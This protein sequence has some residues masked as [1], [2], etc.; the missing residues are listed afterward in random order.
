MKRFA[1]LIF[2]TWMLIVSSCSVFTQTDKPLDK[3]KKYPLTTFERIDI[4]DRMEVN[5]LPSKQYACVVHTNSDDNLKKITP[6][7]KDG[8]LSFTN[9]IAMFFGRTGR[10]VVDIYMP[11]LN[12]IA[13]RGG[14]ICHS[15]VP[16][17]T[18]S[19]TIKLSGGS[20]IEGFKVSC[21]EF[22]GILSG[23]SMLHHFSIKAKNADLKLSGGSLFQDNKLSIADNLLVN[24]SGGSK[25]DFTGKV[26]SLMANISGASHA[27]FFAFEAN[28][29][30]AKVSGASNLKLFVKKTLDIDLFSAST[31]KI[32]G[33]AS[34]KHVSVT[35]M[36]SLEE[37]K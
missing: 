34:L 28:D 21:D 5:L 22:I 25:A 11:T 14:S 12:G 29:C 7:V 24:V 6:T 33:G 13:L 9:D 20:I 17:D 10:I 23:G 8:V 15:K 2:L 19:F 26:Q 31:C 36:S 1:T 32:R 3:S 30:L 18:K 4:A 37:V 16:F 27:D 35:G